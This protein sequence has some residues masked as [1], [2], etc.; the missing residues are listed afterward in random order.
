MLRV[1]GCITEQHDLRLVLLAVVICSFGCYTSL[2]LLTRAR[3]G[4]ERLVAWRWLTAAAVVGGAS[5]WT[6]HFVAMLAFQ[7]G[8]PVGYDITR[9]VL[10][11]AIAMSLSWVGFAIAI[12]FA[13]PASGGAV[14]GTAVGAMHFTGMSALSVPGHLH[15]DPPFAHASL[16]IGIVLGATALWVLARGNELKHRLTAGTILSLA[17]AGLHFTA[18]AAVSLEYDPSVTTTGLVIEPEWL[19][20]AVTAVM[21][22]IVVLGLSGSAVDQHLAE[23]SAREAVR[24]RA[25]IA[26]LQETK[27]QLEATAADLETAL[28]S[29]AAASQAK[30]QFLATM[31]HELRTPLNAVI[32]FSEM[33][34]NES[35]G[36][37]GDAR[38]KDYAKTVQDS[39][40]H[41]L[42]LINDVLD[43]SKVDA[44]RL[45]LQEEELDLGDVIRAA[46]R[47]VDGQAEAA[48]VRLAA[49]V[50][51]DLPTLRA[52]QRRVRQV[53]LNLLS[54]ACKFTPADGEIRVS[55]FRTPDGIA[56]SVE[57][58]GIGIAAEDIP[59]ALERFGQVDNALSR[60]Y[61]GTG[62]GLPLSKR[63]MELHGGSLELASTVGV[64]TIV[65]VTFPQ[66]RLIA[67]RQA[68]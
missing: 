66:A 49:H 31:S 61:E 63:L 8:I 38:Y 10:S 59:R 56:I 62:L 32:G 37:L 4:H 28:E 34:A 2:S 22:M 58:T 23:R 52:D 44:G 35:F 9:T 25:H 26:K 60:K 48:R 13:S 64:G 24:L 19:A 43:F 51:S 5:V 39:G 16:V 54:N 30:S 33:L 36:P 42:S 68:A 12:R 7:P 50:S 46:L 41:L 21:V 40:R 29:A 65:T 18:M 1:Y 47:M 14:F 6:T 57:D 67:D 53:L 17:I 15:W 27:R 20:V 11:I 3:R 45:E 55:A